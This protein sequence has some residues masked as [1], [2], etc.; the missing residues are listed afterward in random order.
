MIDTYI[1]IGMAGVG[2]STI[3]NEVAKHFALPFL[4]VDNVISN[5]YNLPLLKVIDK[6]GV[7]E[8][9]LLESRIVEESTGK[10]VIISPGGSYIYSMNSIDKIKQNSFFIFLN[11]TPQN[12]KNRIQN[13]STRGIIGLESKSFEQLYYER[14][15]AYKKIADVTFNL[16]KKSFRQTT[17]DIISYLSFY[18]P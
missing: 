9:K 12:I 13:I 7:D 2:K 16:E 18:L 10:N 15:I 11:D 14:E 6:I 17:D 8:F 4:D 1:F 5:Q 3:G